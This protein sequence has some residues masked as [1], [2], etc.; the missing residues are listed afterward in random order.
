LG[1]HEARNARGKTAT[2]TPAQ[3]N[4]KRLHSTSEVHSWLVAMF[5]RQLARD[6]MSNVVLRGPLG[7]FS[8]DKP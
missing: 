5:S 6:W 1:K 3:A 8:Y 7:V 2:A 4:N